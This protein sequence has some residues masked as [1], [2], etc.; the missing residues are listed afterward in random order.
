[1]A[2]A[3]T[4]TMAVVTTRGTKQCP[5]EAEAT[6]PVPATLEAAAKVP[7]ETPATCSGTAEGPATEVGAAMLPCNKACKG[8]GKFRQWQK[9]HSFFS[10]FS[11]SSPRGLFALEQTVLIT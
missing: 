9:S 6:V 11:C 7:A 1:V 3:E 5:T 2:A 8:N 10:P 4:T